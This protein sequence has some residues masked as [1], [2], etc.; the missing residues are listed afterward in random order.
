MHKTIRVAIKS[1][2]MSSLLFGSDCIKLLT[3][4]IYFFAYQS[5]LFLHLQTR[6]IFFISAQNSH[7]LCYLIR[8]FPKKECKISNK[9]FSN[10]HWKR[11]ES[12]LQRSYCSYL[13]ATLL[14]FQSLIHFRY[15][16]FWYTYVDKRLKERRVFEFLIFWLFTFFSFS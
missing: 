7:T 14:K 10:A 1:N 9:I 3:I 16:K 11:W 12:G 13:I 8:I 5:W 15:C 6:F 2:V 4:Y